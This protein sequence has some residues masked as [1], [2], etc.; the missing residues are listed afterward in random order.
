MYIK[1]KLKLG[2]STHTNLL[3]YLKKKLI[4]SINYEVQISRVM[5]ICKYTMKVFEILMFLMKINK[6]RRFM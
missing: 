6:C 2:L 4:K 5:I 3:W 1:K